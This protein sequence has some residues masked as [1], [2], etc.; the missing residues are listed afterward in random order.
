MGETA[1]IAE[2][3]ETEVMVSDGLITSAV[4]SGTT[5]GLTRDATTAGLATGT[6]A[7]PTGGATI[8]VAVFS[9]G[10]DSMTG[11]DGFSE[12]TNFDLNIEDGGGS[13]LLVIGLLFS[14]SL[15]FVILLLPK[16]FSLEL[17]LVY[18]AD[19]RAENI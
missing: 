17:R 16:I 13:R 19:F 7:L 4:T 10:E 8:A 12:S 3:A 1:L 14:L 9:G 2:T 5:S 15:L 11:F 18:T 6:G